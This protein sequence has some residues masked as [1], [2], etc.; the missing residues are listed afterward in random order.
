MITNLVLTTR[1]DQALKARPRSL[2]GQCGPQPFVYYYQQTIQI[3]MVG[4][5]ILVSQAGLVFPASGI[6]PRTAGQSLF[7][8]SGH[9][10]LKTR[11]CFPTF[12]VIALV[13]RICERPAI[14]SQ[15]NEARELLTG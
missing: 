14:E 5:E 7:S 4:K 2:S 9:L 3:Q 13:T 8:W 1:E 11:S 6:P 15:L 12:D 10:A